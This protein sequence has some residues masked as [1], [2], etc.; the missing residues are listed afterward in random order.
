MI[1]LDTHVLVWL[2]AEPKRLS[3]RAVAAIRS[4]FASG[5]VGIAS[6]SLWELAMLFVRGRLRAPGTPEAAIR[7]LVEQTGVTVH[8][9][10]PEIATLSAQFPQ[11]FPADP[12]DRLISATA[13]VHGIPLVTRD[14]RIRTCQLVQAIW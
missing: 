8:E 7:Q 11:D 5:G 10:T 13:R 6:I 3:R 4:G 12:A 1:L 9:I 14:A 2:A